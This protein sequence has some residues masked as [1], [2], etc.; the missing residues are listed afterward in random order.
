VTRRRRLVVA[1]LA[2]GVAAVIVPLALGEEFPFLD[3][4]M[5]YQ[6][7]RTPELRILEP[8]G[9]VHPGEPIQVRVAFTDFDFQ[10]GLRCRDAVTCTGE[11]PQ[12]LGPGGVAQG[13]IHVYIQEGTGLG[14]PDSKSFCIPG[15][16]VENVAV[17]TCPAITVRGIYR[18]T[19]EFQS[20]SHVSVLK[21]QGKPQDAP[22]SDAVVIRVA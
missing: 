8:T 21:Q 2:A 22:T 18:V 19:A 9:V 5:G 7:V 15:T 1:L 17:G 13:H 10:P 3:T 14:D 4:K 12:T 11:S 16:A 6:P 20:N